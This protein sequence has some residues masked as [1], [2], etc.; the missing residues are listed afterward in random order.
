M[1]PLEP[2]TSQHSLA[3]G[4][5]RLPCHYQVEEEEKVVQVT[6]LKEHADGTKEQI[7]TAH[8][9]DGHT[10]KLQHRVL[11]CWSSFCVSLINNKKCTF[12]FCVS[13]FGHYAGRVRFESSSPMEN[14]ALLI[15]STEVSDEGRYT[16]HISTFP[17][18]N[19]ER[20]ITLSVWSM[21]S[22]PSN[23][24]PPTSHLL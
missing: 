2:V 9:M 14:S 20:R 18:G 19:F 4:E 16:C 8:F 23:H 5:T 17:N 21:F 3:E 13:E 22:P 6:W 1:E 12:S 15:S 10:G 11:G 24:L 7:I